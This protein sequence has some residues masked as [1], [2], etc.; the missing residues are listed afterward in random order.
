MIASQF[1]SFISPFRHLELYNYNLTFTASECINFGL[2]FRAKFNHFF[3][4]AA[5]TVQFS[6]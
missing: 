1:D 4:I 5:I 6:F 2:E 3:Q